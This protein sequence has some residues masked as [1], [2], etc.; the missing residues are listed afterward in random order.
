MSAVSSSWSPPVPSS[1]DHHWEEDEAEVDASIPSTP[2]DGPED[3]I[4][5]PWTRTKPKS[6]P[7]APLRSLDDE[8]DQ[9]DQDEPLHSIDADDDDVPSPSEDRQCR[10]CFAGVDDEPTSGKLISPC[11]CTG[12]M[13]YVHVNCINA[14]RGTGS[15]A[16][17][18]LECPQCHHQYRLRR[19]L[20]SGLAT[21]RPVL[22]ILTTILFTILTI[23][24]GALLHFGLHTLPSIR[25][26]I[27]TARTPV[28]NVFDFNKDEDD[29]WVNDSTVIIVGGGG[30][31]IYDIVL[32]SIQMFT[33]LAIQF[34]HTQSVIFDMIPD[35]VEEAFFWLG[36]RFLLGLAVMGSFSFLS[37]LI[38]F[39]LFGPLQIIN[40]FRGIGFFRNFRRRTEGRSINQVVIIAFVLIGTIRTLFQV[41]GW[42]KRQT[43]RM[44]VYVETQ[45]LEVNSEDRRKAREEA[46]RER[47]ASWTRRWWRER[48]YNTWRG[49]WEMLLRVSILLKIRATDK[50][51]A[52]KARLRPEL[53]D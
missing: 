10:I 18:F 15:N 22:F 46:I 51:E 32:G 42:V 2:I 29:Y 16:K 49:W 13:R 14:W 19:T 37:M 1:S 30:T 45:I 39:S 17:A 9:D 53:G 21:S 48:R 5:A 34:A 11:L 41:Y 31:L 28:S 25:E 3:F 7:D 26:K 8:D 52:F 20:V 47:E 24:N 50:W 4:P 12:S 35:P 44:L 43:H 23:L 40:S 27:F 33:A 38:S 6:E 36:I